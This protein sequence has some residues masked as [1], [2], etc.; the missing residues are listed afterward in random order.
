MCPAARSAA[1]EQAAVIVPAINACI[2]NPALTNA[3]GMSA[4]A[5]RQMLRLGEP[6]VPATQ[7]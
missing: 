5:T 6:I 4:D 3:A 7:S 1:R 2:A